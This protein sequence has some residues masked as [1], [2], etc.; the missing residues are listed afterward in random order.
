MKQRNEPELLHMAAAYC[1]TGERCTQEMR[2]K[3]H[4]AGATPK[5]ADRIIA[6]LLEEKFMSETRYCRSFVNDKFRFNRWG[7]IRIRFELQKK[8]LSPDAIA[9][10][11]DDLDEEAYR[12]TLTALLKEKKRSTKGHSEQELFLKLYRFACG[13]GFEGTLIT[14][15]LKPLF[16]EICDVDDME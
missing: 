11:L 6:R 16:K 12:S 2:E 7:R 14:Q 10:A 1:S 4:A 5:M 8:G 9:K 13:R 3:L 15:C